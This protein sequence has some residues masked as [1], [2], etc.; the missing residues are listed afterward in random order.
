MTVLQ[1]SCLCGG[2]HFEISG[3]VPG[4]VQCHCSLCRKSSG[5]GGIAKI[6]VSAGQLKWLAGEELVRTFARPSGYGSAF[7]AVCGAPA[8][9]ANA[10]RTRY[11]VP[12]GLLDGDPALRVAE[13]IYVG[14]KAQW[15]TIA[16]GAPQHDTM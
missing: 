6:A 16:D 13:H 1:G 3:P 5:A 9:D 15:E 8:P 11:Q 4:I 14:S 2:I 10:R 7:C 12:V